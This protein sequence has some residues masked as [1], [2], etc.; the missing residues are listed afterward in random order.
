MQAI[1][2]KA[3]VFKIGQ[4]GNEIK[5]KS[6]DRRHKVASKDGQ[7]AEGR[8]AG[9]HGGYGYDARPWAVSIKRNKELGQ[10]QVVSIF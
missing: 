5:R 1:R 9:G 10:E 8:R 6:A 7:D 4:F 2:S 3:N